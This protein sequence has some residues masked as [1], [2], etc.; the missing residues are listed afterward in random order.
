MEQTFKRRNNTFYVE[1]K[2]YN[3]LTYFQAKA[4]EKKVTKPEKPS[5]GKKSQKT[6]SPKKSGGKDPVFFK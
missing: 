4:V 5:A 6:P 1:N 3:T 2:V